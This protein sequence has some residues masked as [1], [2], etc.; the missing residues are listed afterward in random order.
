MDQTLDLKEQRKQNFVDAISFKEPKKVPVGAEVI[1]WPLTYRGGTYLD[2]IDDPD[3][4]VEEYIAFL[5]DVP[6]DYIAMSPG[7]S[8]SVRMHET[9]GSK[10]YVIARD[11]TTLQHAQGELSFIAAE[12][13]PKIIDDLEN[14][15]S[16]EWVKRNFPALNVDSPDEAYES[17]KKAAS[18]FKVFT[19]TN[20]RITNN[21]FEERGILNLTDSTSVRF[22]SNLNTLFDHLR[23]IPAT[24]SDLRRRPELVD[25][26]C[27]AIKATKS[28]PYDVKDYIGKPHPL[29]SATYHSECFLSPPLFDKYFFNDFRD[30]CM[31]FMEAGVKFWIKGEG[32]FLNTLDRYRQLPQGSVV[33]MLD[34]DDPFEVHKQIGDWC[35]IGAGITADLLRMGSIEKCKDYVK[36]CFDTFAPGGGFIF[37]QNKPL[38]CGGDATPEVIRAVYELADELSRK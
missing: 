28:F 35:S 3:R 26:A 19:N 7:I 5:D 38:L 6:L 10:S 4:T 16:D 22:G 12:E 11:G 18:I 2:V 24:L 34:E 32:Q 36:K 33:F 1:M 17:L 29:G 37:L 8:H 30:A 9:L 14:F 21:I 20:R 31:P 27:A 25:A 23:G 15:A 13:Y